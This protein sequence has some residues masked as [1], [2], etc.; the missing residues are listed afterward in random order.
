[1]PE[2]V[3]PPAESL[4]RLE[5]RIDAFEARRGRAGPALNQGA[6]DGYRMLGQMLSGVLG[7][8][9]LGWFFDRE[10]GTAPL[11]LL[12]GL[13]T[14]AGL[15]IFAAIRTAL[16]LSARSASTAFEPPRSETLRESPRADREELEEDD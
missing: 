2:P 6:A 15:A 10:V 16:R 3:A 11:G 14:G 4:G 7:G 1:M 13:I 5:A 9:G 12:T 8:L